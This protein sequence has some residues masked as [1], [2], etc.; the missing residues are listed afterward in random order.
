MLISKGAN[1]NLILEWRGSNDSCFFATALHVASYY[2]NLE[3]AKILINSG[4]NPHVK[5]H[6]GQS[7]YDV[8]REKKLEQS[9]FDLFQT[10]KPQVPKPT[11]NSLNTF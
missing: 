4:A 6:K 2:A 9:W 3:V 1:V 11:G 10:Y 7:A 8:V 5:S